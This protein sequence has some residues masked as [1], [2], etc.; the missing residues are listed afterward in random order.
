MLCRKHLYRRRCELI[1]P[2]LRLIGLSEHS[3]DII[4]AFIQF[5]KRGHRKIGCSHKN[6]FQSVSP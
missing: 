1:A 5:F 4:A 2:A 3:R 6:Y